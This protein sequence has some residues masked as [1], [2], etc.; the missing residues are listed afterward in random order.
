MSTTEAKRRLGLSGHRSTAY[1]TVKRSNYLRRTKRKGKPKLTEKHKIERLNWAKENM[2]WTKE[3]RKVMFSDEKKFNL[4][5]PDGNQY[6]WHDIRNEPEYFSKR[7]AGGG[8]IMV[9][10]GIGYGGKTNIVVIKGRSNAEDYRNYIS[11]QF[12][13][14]DKKIGGRSWIFQHVN[15]SIH[16]AKSTIEWLKSKKYRIFPWPA[17]S[18]DMNIIENLWGIMVRKIYANGKQFNS[19]QDLEKAI[20]DCW[21][22]I[23]LGK[24]KKIGGINA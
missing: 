24:I 22:D 9:W 8:G 2:C 15:A 17:R 1:M 3:W 12:K 4:D 6:Y 7:Q 13:T 20:L 23:E 10:A 11:D 19:I 18:P 16:K 14:F 21:D 5:G